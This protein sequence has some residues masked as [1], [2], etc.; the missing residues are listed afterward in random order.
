MGWIAL[1]SWGEVLGL[2]DEDL[3][4]VKPSPST[5]PGRPILPR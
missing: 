4:V 5:H 2:Q 1:E 3:D